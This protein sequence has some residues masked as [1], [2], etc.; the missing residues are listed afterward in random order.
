MTTLLTLEQSDAAL[1]ERAQAGDREA[2]AVL[3]RR[4]TGPL[5]GHA[6]ALLG[7]GPEAEDLVQEALLRAWRGLDRH[8]PGRSFAA[9]VHTILHRAGVDWL[10]ARRPHAALEE[11]DA[12]VD[13]P[14]PPLR[15]EEVAG[16][17]AALAALTPRQREVLHCRYGLGLDAAGTAARLETSPGNVR[18]AL[19][20]A[21][22]ALRRQLGASGPSDQPQRQ[23]P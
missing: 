8:L 13:D 16:L 2:F 18:V 3:V 20:R 4:H 5:L 11:D 19:H 14:G 15:L 22:A 7:P 12:P 1:A 6:R 21:L 17:P 9:W 10:R 23:T